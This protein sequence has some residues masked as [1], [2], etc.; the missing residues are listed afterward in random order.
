MT[1]QD[2]RTRDEPFSIDPQN[3]GPGEII[4]ENEKLLGGLAYASQILLPGVLPAV[5]LISKETST[6]K[7][8]RYHAVHGLALLVAT[9]LYYIVAI[10]V[11]VIVSAFA[12]CLLCL[13][14]IAF[15]LPLPVLLYYAVMAFQGKYAEIPWLTRFLSDNKWV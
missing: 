1:S 8:V 15:L 2:P 14:W 6:S 11:N 5:L 3:T 13:L 12:S 9:I 10:I 4:T 7:F